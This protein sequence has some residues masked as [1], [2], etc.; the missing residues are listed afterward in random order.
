[1]ATQGLEYHISL[2]DQMTSPLKGVMKSVDALQTRSQ[3]AM[4]SI[5][6][7][8][9]GLW[10]VGASLKNALDPA[11][12]FSRAMNEVKATGM[13]AEGLAQVEKFALNFSSTFGIASTDVVNSVNEIARAIDGLTDSEMIAFSESAN[14]LAKATGS[15]TA[16][17]GSYIATMSNIFQDEM[18]RLGKSDWVKQMA[19]QATL[20]ANMF[21][22]SGESLSAAFSNLGSTAKNAGV[23]MAEQFAILGN[24]QGIMDGAKSGTAYRALI[25]NAINST[26]MQKKLGM[27]F[28]D[29]KGLLLPITSII[30]KIKKKFGNLGKAELQ[31]KLASAFGVG[32]SIAS[33]LLDKTDQITEQID[34]IGKIK[35]L[36]EAYE[37]SKVTTDSWMRLYHI[38]QNIKIAIGGQVLKKIE[39]FMQKIADLAQDFQKWL[40]TYQNIARWIGYLIGAIIGFAAVAPAITLLTGAF[41]LLKVG[42]IATFA[43]VLKLSRLITALLN[44]F[45]W[46]RGA[47][48]LLRGS[49]YTVI[50][51]ALKPFTLALAVIKNPALILRGVF[52]VLTKAVMLFAGAFRLA[53]AATGI[54]LII[55]LGVVIYKFRHQFKDLWEGVK[56]GFGSLESHLAPLYRAFDIVKSAGQKILGAIGRIAGAFNANAHSAQTFQDV[57]VA[58][59]QAL[60][61]V[62]DLALG[63]VELVAHGF[64][65]MADLFAISIGAMIEGWTA[66]TTLWDSDKPLESFL[67]IAKALGKIFLNA[68][69][70]IVNSFTDVIN[71][72]IK[73]ANTL[74]GI[75]IP[76]IPKWED[77]TLPAKGSA[78]AVGA[79]IG[80]QAL[81]MQNQIGALSTTSPK[82]ELSEQTKPQLTK[83]P[84][85]SVS[86]TITQNRTEQRTVNYGGFAFYGY[87]KN[88][89]MRDIRSREELKA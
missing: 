83:M 77:S 34:K 21:K 71:F 57:G 75:N 14:I 70:G 30:G 80:A 67:N 65:F 88:E 54:G 79:S 5:A 9:A 40:Q 76:L 74:P 4:K 69:R 36:D 7:G 2:I 44:P 32:S 73:K 82:F 33:L 29:E 56:Q 19:G 31:D 12:D 16:Q 60:G 61:F 72:I 59:G 50:A 37:V 51:M 68:F 55:A 62:F 85:G 42:V 35:N 24:T 81:Q 13:G 3:K 47:F 26:K 15:S 66:I 45:N 87:D 22:S 64:S 1:M 41:A 89:I 46:L 17:M 63:A 6:M 78:T 49:I 58:L 53:F 11:I 18:D 10:G 8:A 84:S 23:S 38:M 86:K 48:L 39:P 43:P 28:V 52:Y 25:E 27:T 20:T